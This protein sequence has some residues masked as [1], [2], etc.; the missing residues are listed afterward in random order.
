MVHLKVFGVF[1]DYCI[2][3][4]DSVSA[5]KIEHDFDTQFFLIR[6]RYQ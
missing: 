4:H 3:V 2:Y 5:V 1:R 6:S